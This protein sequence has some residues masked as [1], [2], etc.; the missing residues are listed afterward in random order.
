[1]KSPGNA[2]RTV[3]WSKDLGARPFLLKSLRNI[4]GNRASLTLLIKHTAVVLSYI[5]EKI[6]SGTS[7]P[8]QVPSSADSDIAFKPSQERCILIAVGLYIMF[9]RHL[10]HKLLCRA[11][12]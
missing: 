3:F 9:F 1:M 11:P 8:L 10:V 6:T 7:M 4:Q 2:I 5:R 12:T